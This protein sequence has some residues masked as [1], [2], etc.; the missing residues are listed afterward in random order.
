MSSQEIPITLTPQQAAHGV[1][2][3]VPLPSGTGTARLRIPS[4]QDGALVRARLGDT[5]V[6]LRIRVAAGAGPVAGP[7]T[8]PIPVPVPGQQPA[9][10]GT[11]G[12]NGTPGARGCLVAVA[13]VAAVIVGLVLLNSGNDDDTTASGSPA[14]SPSDTPSY[15]PSY[16]PPS[17]APAPP[18][19]AAPTTPADPST[20]AAAPPAASPSEAAPSPF[21]RGTC[22]NGRLPD[23][24]TAQTVTGVSEV[25]C[26]AS[27]AHYK[28][29]QSIPLTSDLNRC[30]DNPKTQYAFSYRY[31]RNG[32]PVNEYVY[33]LVGIGS[34][35]RP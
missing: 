11:P 29:I 9:A 15:T 13:V 17:S 5:D 20:E 21:D 23:S 10:A 26:S 30:N 28:V 7:T 35:A 8:A 24:T 12:A 22:L 3:T 14:P 27:D 16:T 4:T 32:I 18:Q 2:L 34:Y 19:S 33:C 1:I 31:T 6:L 25:S